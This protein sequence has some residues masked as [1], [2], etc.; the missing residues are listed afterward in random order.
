MMDGFGMEV[1]SQ[2]IK[3]PEAP[4]EAERRKY[5]N[6]KLRELDKNVYLVID[7]LDRVQNREYQEIMFKVIREVIG[8]DELQNPLSGG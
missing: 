2:V 7:D 1:L 4:S 8:T 6:D 5:L 3:F